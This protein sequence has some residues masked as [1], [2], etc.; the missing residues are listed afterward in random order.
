[1]RKTLKNSWLKYTALLLT[2]LSVFNMGY[3]DKILGY[4][5]P[6]TGGC[7]SGT[8]AGAASAQECSVRCSQTMGCQGFTFISGNT[9]PNC[10]ITMSACMLSGLGMFYVKFNDTKT[11]NAVTG[12]QQQ[13]IGMSGRDCQGYD[14]NTSAIQTDLYGCGRQCTLDPECKGF[15]INSN[16]CFLKKQMQMCNYTT[17]NGFS[18]YEKSGSPTGG[19]NNFAGDPCPVGNPN[20][21]QQL[22]DGNLPGS[23]RNQAVIYPR[24]NRAGK[25]VA[26]TD[27]SDAI[28]GQ[29]S[30][31]A[32]VMLQANDVYP[33]SHVSSRVSGENYLSSIIPTKYNNKALAEAA[34]RRS[35]LGAENFSGPAVTQT[36]VRDWV[37]YHLANYCDPL[38]AKLN[39][40]GCANPKIT[41]AD[42]A[43]GKINGVTPWESSKPRFAADVTA[44]TLMQSKISDNEAA[45]RYAYN[46][47]NIMPSPI[48]TNQP[49][50]SVPDK[51]INPNYNGLKV[52]KDGGYGVY[53]NYLARQSKLSLA[54]YAVT[55]LFA[56]RMVLSNLKIPV[57]RWNDAGKK[58]VTFEPT[59][60]QGLLEFEANKRFS[61]PEWYDRVQQMPT[62]ALM[63]EMAYMQA[64]QLTIEFK[65][66]EQQQIQT[67]LF[68]S[69]ASDISA[70]L[71]MA[72]DMQEQSS[73]DTASQISNSLKSLGIN[74]PGKP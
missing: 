21:A 6:I 11:I 67:A 26:T 53:M 65:R 39:L 9:T 23:D 43:N 25:T 5:P 64:L 1:M 59:S 57:A 55:Q 62:P 72:Q 45:M 30:Y 69:L 8:S 44:T 12:E 32:R 15:S 18:Y 10:Y 41:I 13:F 14:I 27:A 36:V 35:F 49:D 3:A 4:S 66:Y 34:L 46:V 42:I 40:H 17:S 54:Q 20:C 38:A 68:A 52:L 29:T 31:L 19:D 48:T 73:A 47:T 61:D 28:L 58:S 60:R 33:P 70:M 37:E 16:T 24:I 51:Y 2:T 71:K 22:R 7:L 63:K 50:F 56:D 74:V